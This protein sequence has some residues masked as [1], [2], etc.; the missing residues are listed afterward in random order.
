MPEVLIDDICYVPVAEI[1]KLTDERLVNCLS[2]LIE[3]HYFQEK[4]KCLGIT[5]NAIHALL[6]MQ[7]MRYLQSWRSL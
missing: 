3:L 6:G 5:W 1:P 4:H 7:Y 2:S